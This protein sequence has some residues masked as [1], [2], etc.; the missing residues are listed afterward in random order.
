MLGWGV[1]MS[2]RLYC[3]TRYDALAQLITG[4]TYWA[5]PGALGEYHLKPVM[6][7][8]H[9]LPQVSKSNDSAFMPGL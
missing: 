1:L 3:T 5:A 9:V 6:Q 2:V 4:C 8:G 7:N